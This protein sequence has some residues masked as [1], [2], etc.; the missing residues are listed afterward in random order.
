MTLQ[1]LQTIDIPLH[2]LT[3]WDGNVRTSGAEN[4]LAEL[5]ASITSV[6]LLHSLVV[7]KAKRGQYAVVAGRRRFLA[8]TQMVGSGNVKRSFPVPCRVAPEDA[9]LTEIS[10]AENVVRE[11]MS[12][13]SELQAFLRLVETGKCVADV[14]A[15]FGVSE[16]VVNRRLALARVSPVLLDLYSNDQMPLDVL[17]AFTLTDDQPLKSVSGTNSNRGIASRT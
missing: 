1:D 15:R 13:L 9:D 17:Q 4:G 10:L 2:K 6:G 12:V 3:L 5:I 8:L 11:E 14:A 16:A 7:H